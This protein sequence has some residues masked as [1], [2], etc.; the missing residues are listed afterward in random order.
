MNIIPLKANLIKG[1][2]GRIPEDNLDYPIF[3]TNSNGLLEQE[4]IQSTM[5][6]QLISKLLTS[7][8]L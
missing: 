1:S 8:N 2:H 6:Y 5:V 7:K 4:Q 3:I